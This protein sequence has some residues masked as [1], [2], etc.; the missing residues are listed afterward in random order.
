MK[1][2]VV[3]TWAKIKE[4]LTDVKVVGSALLF[5]W[6]GT[7]FALDTRYLT[8]ANYAEGTRQS[9]QREVSALE[10]RLGFAQTEREKQ[11]LRAL[12][13]VKKQQIKEVK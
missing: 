13:A 9:L 2:V 5:L 11:I 3:M 8:L 10:I 6:A 7:V 4:L 1:R 12:I